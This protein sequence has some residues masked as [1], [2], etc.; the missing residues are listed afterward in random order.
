MVRVMA[1]GAAAAFVVPTTAA[2]AA[3]PP[4]LGWS[5]VTSAGAYGYGTVASL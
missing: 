5:P 3:S 1:A 4:S 2:S